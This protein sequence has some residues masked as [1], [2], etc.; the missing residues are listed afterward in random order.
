MKTVP[1]ASVTEDYDDVVAAIARYA[2]APGPEIA[3]AHP[4]A[5]LVLA[6]TLGAALQA[7]RDSDA[8]QAARPMFPT[9]LDTPARVPGTGWRT[10]PVDAAFSFGC[11]IRWQDF[12][13]TWLAHEWGHPSDNL[14]GLL[15]LADHLARTGQPLRGAD[16]LSAL[17][18]AHEIQGVL[19]LGTAL[20]R[21]GL[22]HVAFVRVATAAVAAALLTDDVDVAAA[23]VSH[24]LVDG[25]PTR[26]YRQ[27][28]NTGPRKSWAAADATARGVWLAHRAAR[29]EPPVRIPVTAPSY[30]FS[31][32]LLGGTPLALPQPLST[33][34][35]PRVLL[36]PAWPAEYHAQS[37][38]EAALTLR[39][40]VADAEN[41]ITTVEV[42][43]H[44]AAIRIIDKTGPLNGPADRDHCLQYIVAAA[45]LYGEVT[46]ATYHDEVATDPRIDELRAKISVREEPEFTHAY[47]DPDER[48]V[49]S[50][51]QIR[52]ADGSVTGPATV[53]LPVG[54]PR[55]RGEA[56]S[57][58]DTKLATGLR[59]ALGPHRAPA[60]QALLADPDK[61][62]ETQLPTIVDALV[63]DDGKESR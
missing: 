22:D 29:G 17:T 1:T 41:D 3:A 63:P 11:L 2:V 60:G 38:L 52:F 5:A 43:T 49:A 51:I 46:A 7:T 9:G 32:A 58:V 12:N 25:A 27:A 55:R 4:D 30:G 28:P 37:A 36:K 24:A 13:D 48:A 15:P 18:R 26:A 44:E 53:R 14:G 21:H 45:L 57:L 10:D 33:Y 34:I 59:G 40:E 50:R 61:L 39:P 62:A 56:R 31:D 19:A 47:H 20:N 35:V 54:H 16:L 42:H 8:V 23:A 6:D